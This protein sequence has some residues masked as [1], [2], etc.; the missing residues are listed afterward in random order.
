[1]FFTRLVYHARA[2]IENSSKGISGNACFPDE[3]TKRNPRTI[4][5]GEAATVVDML[6]LQEAR[7][8]IKR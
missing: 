7:S 6:E 1:M 8:E 5:Y 4:Q 3:E 2:A